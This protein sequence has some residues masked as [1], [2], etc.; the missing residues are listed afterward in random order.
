MTCKALKLSI[1]ILID[2][3]SGKLSCAIETSHDSN[4]LGSA[5]SADGRRFAVVKG[6]SGGTRQLSTII[7]WDLSTGKLLGK[8]DEKKPVACVALSS[9]GRLAATGYT[10]GTVN[11]WDVDARRLVGSDTPS[12]AAVKDLLFCQGDK[13][14]IAKTASQPT[15]VLWDVADKLTFR[16]PLQRPDK[17]TNQLDLPMPGLAGESVG[18]RV[19]DRSGSILTL[20]LRTDGMKLLG[21]WEGP[22]PHSI[23]AYWEPSSGQLVKSYFLPPQLRGQD[24][25]NLSPDGGTF[26]DNEMRIRD[27]TSFYNV[28]AGPSATLKHSA[29]ALGAAFG[30]AEQIVT[31]GGEVTGE[32]EVAAGAAVWSKETQG[33]RYRRGKVER[34]SL[35][36]R[37]LVGSADGRHVAAATTD[38]DPGSKTRLQLGGAPSAHVESDSVLLCD[39][40][41]D[42][43]HTLDCPAKPTALAY[44]PDGKTLAIAF[45]GYEREKVATN[46]IQLCDVDRAA[47]TDQLGVPLDAPATALD[48]SDSG[49]TVA[50]AYEHEEQSHIL[51]RD[52]ESGRDADLAFD[53]PFTAMQFVPGSK[54]IAWLSAGDASKIFIWDVDAERVHATIET[55]YFPTTFTISPNGRLLAV[56][57]H[58]QSWGN[59]AIYDLQSTRMVHVLRW[60]SSRDEKSRALGS[61]AFSA[62]G[63]KIVACDGSNEVTVWDLP[64]EALKP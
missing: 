51:L 17:K 47:F 14:L 58:I 12:N 61:L 52:V 33:G 13:A 57:S 32:G 10:T 55:D 9:D 16:G 37:L 42:K 34:S 30:V 60:R 11:I 43:P 29:A 28:S 45:K 53:V 38:G 25:K 63:A 6:E 56:L 18:M 48:V 5:M 7:V 35:P 39:L 41:G 2:V 54:Q 40:G 4:T 49:E 50:A 31:A 26:V 1:Y 15:M 22:P 23:L 64:S 44:F 8:V 27:L 46:Y 62:D 20:E 59:V 3:E 24:L 36:L 19:D 21:D